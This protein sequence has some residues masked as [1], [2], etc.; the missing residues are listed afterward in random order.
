MDEAMAVAVLD[1]TDSDSDLEDIVLLNVDINRDIENRAQLYGIF[2]LDEV[3]PSHCKLYFR[4]EKND[5]PRLA[6][7]LRVPQVIY[8][9]SGH[10][11]SGIEGL[12][13]LLRRLAYPNRLIDLEQFFGRSSTA[14]SKIIDCMTHHIYFNF[15]YLLTNL[16]NLHWLNLDRLRNYSQAIQNKGAP[17]PN[18]WGFIDG[19]TRGIC[20]PTENQEAY[21]SGHKRYHCV[22]YQAVVTPDGMIVS[23]KGAY[24]GRKHDAGIFRESDFYAELEECMMF[25]NNENFVLYGDQAYGIR[26]LLLCPYPTRQN[27]APDHQEFNT[28]MSNVRTAVEWG[29]GKIVSEFA[30]MDFKKNQKLLLQE[31]GT[32]YSTAVILTNC[33]SC[34]YKNQT[35]L[36]FNVNPIELEEYLQ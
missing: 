30:F 8:T 20:R 32:L 21:Y 27:M 28:Q 18:C 34:L 5:I 24:E 6:E 4:F 26:E 33:H 7:S 35:S 22:K 12:C 14:L 17:I 36:Y 31:V 19:T 25:P 23:L 10:N 13:I 3:P 1:D 15:N 9:D 11:V 29:F 16:R 2:N